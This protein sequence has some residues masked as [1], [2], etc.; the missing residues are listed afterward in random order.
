M[1]KRKVR[2]PNVEIPPIFILR[3]GQTEWNLGHR[4]QGSLDSPLTA[5]G[6][7]QAVVQQRLLAE[8]FA[9]ETAQ[10]VVSPL[11]RTRQTAEIALRGHKLVSPPRFD[12]RIAE[13]SAGL[14]EGLER[15]EIKRL[16]PSSCQASCD[17]EYYTG[18]INGEGVDKLR[19]RCTT[20]LNE[21]TT[22]TVLI[23]HGICSVMLRGIL[24]GLEHQ[25]MCKL[26]LTQGCIFEVRDGVEVILQEAK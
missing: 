22:T 20:F 25:A 13:I 10:V 2:G 4:L 23:T 16:W 11:G 6:K 8:V 15:S 19:K 14:W 26:P 7:E 18:A 17:F 21:L 3:H 5:R 1:K 24:C 12:P 9:R